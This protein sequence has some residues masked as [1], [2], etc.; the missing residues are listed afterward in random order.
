MAEGPTDWKVVVVLDRRA[1]V[2]DIDKLVRIL[3][4]QRV[5]VTISASSREEDALK[6][7]EEHLQRIN[8]IP[9]VYIKAMHP[10]KLPT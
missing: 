10:R 3:A 5:I 1:L 8:G 7:A 4:R 6:K 2:E 9:M